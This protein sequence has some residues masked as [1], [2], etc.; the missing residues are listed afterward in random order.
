MTIIEKPPI[1]IELI[2]SKPEI[3]LNDFSTQFDVRGPLTIDASKS[4]SPD[5]NPP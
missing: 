5:H 4:Y 3:I 1:N 2:A